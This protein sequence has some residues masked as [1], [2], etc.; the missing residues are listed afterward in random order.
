MDHGDT[1]NTEKNGLMVNGVSAEPLTL[2]PLPF[3]VSSVSL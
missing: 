2:Y 3:S 1:E